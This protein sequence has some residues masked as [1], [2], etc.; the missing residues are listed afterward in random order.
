M[1]H[2]TPKRSFQGKIEEAGTR[3][4][5]ETYAP[6]NLLVG[7][8]QL[9]LQEEICFEK[10]E[11]CRNPEED[12]IEM[13]ENGDLENGVRVKMN[14][15]NLVVLQESTEKIADWEAK[16]VL[17]E[18][19]EHHNFISVGC[20]NVLAGGRAPLQHHTVWVKMARNKLANLMFITNRWLEQVW[21]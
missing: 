18:G 14:Q 17:E 21:V 10:W 6:D 9:V 5:L 20:Q 16:P 7:G 4:G 15:L 8:T 12:F 1:S 11:V 3:V 2:A 19:G 13:D